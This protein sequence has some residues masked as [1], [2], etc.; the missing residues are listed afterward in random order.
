M[1]Q[2]GYIRGLYQELERES[3]EIWFREVLERERDEKVIENSFLLTYYM[4]RPLEWPKLSSIV[5]HKIGW[6]LKRPKRHSSEQW[7]PH[8]SFTNK[9]RPLEQPKLCSS[10][11]LSTPRSFT[12][13]KKYWRDAKT[14]RA[15]KASLGLLRKDKD[16]N[17]FEKLIPNLIQTQRTTPNNQTQ[18]TTRWKR[19]KQ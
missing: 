5:R 6:P 15:I 3:E 4:H 11:A 14:A 18:P 12:D 13:L 16:N 1:L 19:Y 10:E 2:L 9:R 7:P 17:S 8:R